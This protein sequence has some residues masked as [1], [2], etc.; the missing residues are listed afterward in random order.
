MKVKIRD[1]N[2]LHNESGSTTPFFKSKNI[3]WTRL[4]DDTPI[5]VYTD[6]CI[7]LVEK[8]ASSDTKKIAWLLEPMV[9][10]RDPYDFIRNNHNLFDIVASHDIQFVSSIPNAV[11]VPYGT[12]WIRQ[13]DWGGS[14]KT[15]DISLIASEKNYTIGHRLRHRCAELSKHRVHLYGKAYNPIKNKSEALASY[16]YSIA[17]ENCK[18]DGYFT[19]KLIDC[20][21]CKTIPI[22]W[23]SD[24]VSSIF[25]PN[26]IISL[27]SSNDLD[28]CITK[29]TESFYNYNIKAIE[30]N[31]QRAMDF[32]TAEDQLYNIMK[33]PHENQ[34]STIVTDDRTKH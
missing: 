4:I 30:D 2:F 31:Y 27:T 24:N 32:I 12:T 13:E 17:I 22:Y 7:S 8:L 25:N 11:Y 9:I 29:A 23:G 20:F 26:G 15:N 18:V 19:E 16:R 28:N 5:V 34:S 33:E 10:N 1:V 21:A 14:T 3:E 6:Y